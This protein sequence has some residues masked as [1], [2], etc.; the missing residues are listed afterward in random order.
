MKKIISFLTDPFTKNLHH[1]LSIFVLIA[2]FDVIYFYFDKG[3]KEHVFCLSSHL[4]L[5]AYFAVAI[6]GLLPHAI[7]KIYFFV[8]YLFCGSYFLLGTFSYLSIH[9]NPRADF[10]FAILDTNPNEASEFLTTYINAKVITVIIGIPIL[11]F[12]ISKLIKKT[13]KKG[14]TIK[15]FIGISLILIGIALFSYRPSVWVDGILSV[16][17][18]TFFKFE[19]CPDL[20]KYATHPQLIYQD[21]HPKNIVI[22]IGESE[23]RNHSSLYGYELPTNPKLE[24]L[25]DD[26]LL[27]VYSNVTSPGIQTAQVF[28]CLLNTAHPEDDGNSKWYESTTIFDVTRLCGYKST[29]ISNQ[30]K[31][32]IWDNLV[33]KYSELSDTAIF[34]GNKYSGLERQ[35]Y[36]GELL[37]IVKSMASSYKDQSL[38]LTIIHLMGSHEAFFMRYPSEFAVFKSSDYQG[39]PENQR[40]I[41][42]SYDNS[43]LYN[44]YIVSELISFFSKKEAVVFYFS[45]HGMDIF[46]SDANYS[47]HSTPNPQS[48]KVGIQI[49]FIIYVSPLFQQHFPSTIKR[50]KDTLHKPFRTDNL[51]YTVMDVA[52]LSFKDNDDVKKNSL[53]STP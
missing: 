23:T 12:V 52:G 48:Q 31:H 24:K 19:K 25:R 10:I 28:Q 14:I 35:W 11:L 51:I 33:G 20:K 6:S 42:A 45:D 13:K 29:W 46:E 47:G 39:R 27:F 44:D 49:P 1:L 7:K 50:M 18:F 53:F 5:L 34:V 41:L 17:Y 16:Y 30:S 38:A 22:I 26:S 36:D 37:P 40:E 9:I 8:V 4:L 3:Y 43:I 15:S 2:T 21:S 32:G